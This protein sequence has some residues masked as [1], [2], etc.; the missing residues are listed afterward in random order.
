VLLLYH[1]V[2]SGAIVTSSMPL[3][4]RPALAFPK[5]G[6]SVSTL[7]PL[8]GSRLLAIRNGIP[9]QGM[10][11]LFSSS[12]TTILGKRGH[13]LYTNSSCKFL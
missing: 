2:D 10:Q 1:P 12:E 3:V 7:S 5:N 8:F 11:V 6:L 13:F 9:L 4:P